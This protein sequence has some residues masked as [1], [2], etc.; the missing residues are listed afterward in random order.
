MLYQSSMGA[1]SSEWSSEGRVKN[2]MVRT[3]HGN[4]MVQCQMSTEVLFQLYC[5]EVYLEPFT[6]NIVYL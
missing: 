2:S 3:S 5:K 4:G 1:C 6:F